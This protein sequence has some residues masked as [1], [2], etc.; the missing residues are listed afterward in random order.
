MSSISTEIDDEM[1]YISRESQISLITSP[2]D[3]NRRS[4]VNESYFHS[5]K[6][7]CFGNFFFE[8]D[9]TFGACTVLTFVKTKSA[10]FE[11]SPHIIDISLWFECYGNKWLQCISAFA[12]PDP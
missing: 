7:G 9:G 3:T 11:K 1:D 2:I 4:E 8:E 6:F 10:P 5:F 12:L